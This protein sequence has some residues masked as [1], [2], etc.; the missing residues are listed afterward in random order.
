MK[1]ELRLEIFLKKSRLR[2]EV[3]TRLDKAKTA[4]E[5]ALEL[6]KHRSSVS[7]VLLDMKK[8]GLIKCVNPADKNF[9]HYIKKH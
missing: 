4:T 1:K 2:R 6:K 7:R 8:E 3:W 9:R 5:I